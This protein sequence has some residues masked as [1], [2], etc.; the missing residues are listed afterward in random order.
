MNDKFATLL[1][2]IA[3]M[4]QIQAK[5]STNVKE[6]CLEPVLSLS[7]GVPHAE[8]AR[9]GLSAISFFRASKKD[10]ATIPNAA[11]SANL[12]LSFRGT[13]N[14]IIKPL[15]WL[16]SSSQ[17]TNSHNAHPPPKA[18]A[19]ERG[20]GFLHSSNIV[21]LRRIRNSYQP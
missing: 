21:R 4:P 3:T 14:L 2:I 5:T 9:V 15:K 6:V 8:K 18:D 10:T 16:S 7:E 13:R 12:T 17:Q 1:T 20:G 11:Q 19:E